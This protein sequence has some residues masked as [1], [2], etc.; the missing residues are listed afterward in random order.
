MLSLNRGSV[1]LAGNTP[2]D[3]IAEAS[4]LAWDVQNF[5]YEVE[6]FRLRIALPMLGYAQATPIEEQDQPDSSTE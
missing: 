6:A 4:W 2:A 3:P 1:N 5:Q